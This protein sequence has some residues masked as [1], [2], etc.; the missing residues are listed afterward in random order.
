MSSKFIA[1]T[2]G[3]PA[4]IGPEISLKAASMPEFMDY[5]VIYG[6]YEVLEYYRKLLKIDIPLANIK[7]IREFQT[8]KINVVSVV[9]I[10]MDDFEIGKV[11]S[12]CGD[13]AY[14]Y[15]D[16]AIADA[17]AGDFKIVTTAPLNKE[18]LHKGGHKFDG[19]TEIFA[20]LTNTK[21]YTMLLWSDAMAVVHVSTH[22]SLRQACDRAKKARVLECI[23][24]AHQ[25]MSDL[26]VKNPRIAVAGLNPHSGEAGLFG[27]EEIDEIIPAI[28]EAIA[29]GLNVD[30]PVPPDTVYL[31][32][33]QKKY[34]IVVAMYHDQG[35]IPMKLLAFDSGVNVTLGLPIIRTSVDHGTAFDIA[36]RGIANSE[37]MCCALNLGKR[38]L[39]N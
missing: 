21:K 29:N 16:R 14:Q 39:V 17:M 11:S 36:G 34:D 12:L 31:K 5:S 4:G 1:I 20:T 18:A 19:H 33:V 2:M 28:N 37:S 25:A 35:H 38:F 13:C 7:N 26:G 23:N 15:L 24:L 6:S 32:A 22:C 8:G 9:N 3:D 10:S 30:G 27:T